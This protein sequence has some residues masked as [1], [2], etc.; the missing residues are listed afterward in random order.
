M[1]LGLPCSLSGLHVG[2]SHKNT[3]VDHWS[4]NGMAHPLNGDTLLHTVLSVSLGLAGDMSDSDPIGR[5]A[6]TVCSTF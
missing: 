1:V 5:Y 6:D 2:H 3:S 4:D